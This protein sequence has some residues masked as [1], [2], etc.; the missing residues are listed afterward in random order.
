MGTQ[1]IPIQSSDYGASLPGTFSQQYSSYAGCEGTW[2]MESTL[3]D[4]P[5]V[6]AAKVASA[7]GVI[8]PQSSTRLS[9]ITDGTSNTLFFG[10]RAHGIFS[11]S[12][13][14]YYMRWNS[15]DWSDTFM[16]A[17]FPPNGYKKFM[18]QDQQGLNGSGGIYAGGW[19]WTPLECASSFHPGGVNYSFCDGSVRFIKDTI[20]SWQNDVTDYGYPVGIGS[21]PN[22][23]YAMGTA[24]P[25]VFQKLSTRNGGEV[26]SSDSY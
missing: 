17:M 4:G 3:N 11:G 1:S 18:T 12:D 15:G 26:L 9:S 23:E 6:F 16:D 19:W 8:Y 22:G 24:V 7:N 20:S 10:E 21:G 25:Q 5:T 13:L 14:H 2:A